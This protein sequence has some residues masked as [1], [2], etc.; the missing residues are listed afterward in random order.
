VFTGIRPG[1]KIHEIM[2]SEEERHRTIERGGYYVIAPMLPEL[3]RAA[4][5]EPVLAGEYSSAD[6]TL[7]LRG[8]R[9]LLSGQL[10]EDRPAGAI[11]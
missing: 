6:V 1:E 4:L 7:D 10:T 9:E 2:V 3:R 8:L 5:G 11:A